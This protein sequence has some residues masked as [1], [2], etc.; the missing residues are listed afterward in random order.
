M[1][2]TQLRPSFSYA[3]RT[4]ANAHD[5]LVTLHRRMVTSEDYS[6]AALIVA[7]D[8]DIDVTLQRVRSL[9][10]NAADVPSTPLAVEPLIQTIKQYIAPLERVIAAELECQ[11]C[12]KTTT[13]SQPTD[14]IPGTLRQ[15]E[16]MLA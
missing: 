1:L 6:L 14:P 13:H 4:I 15:S 16:K 2:R 12:H 3:L 5:L 10:D 7:F 8:A 9:W 11:T